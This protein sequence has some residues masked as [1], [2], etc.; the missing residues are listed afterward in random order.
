[1]ISQNHPS[2]ARE[3]IEF[4]LEKWLDSARNWISLPEGAQPVLKTTSKKAPSM[5]TL[6]RLLQQSITDTMTKRSDGKAIPHWRVDQADAAFSILSKMS[7]GCDRPGLDWKTR[8]HATLS[9]LSHT[10]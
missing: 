2:A 10:N 5:T 1:V 4:D 7:R 6:M 3:I 9:C 8:L